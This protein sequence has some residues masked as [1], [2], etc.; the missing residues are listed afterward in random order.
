MVHLTSHIIRM[1]PGFL[2]GI[3]IL[4]DYLERTPHPKCFTYDCGG[5]AIY[6]IPFQIDKK[7]SYYFR[8]EK[9]I[10]VVDCISIREF[11][12]PNNHEIIEKSRLE[13]IMEQ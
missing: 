7:C 1:Y 12:D 5:P 3:V 2:Y 6:V 9:C 8:C 10:P 13:I 4:S 11:L